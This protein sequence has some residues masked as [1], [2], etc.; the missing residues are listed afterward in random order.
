[1]PPWTEI[2]CIYRDGGKLSPPSSINFIDNNLQENINKYYILS[3]K[4]F[5]RLFDVCYLLLLI[6]SHDETALN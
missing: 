1:M 3:Q 4:N 6:L 5:F 2:A